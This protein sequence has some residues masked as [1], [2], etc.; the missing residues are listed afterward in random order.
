MKHA[1]LQERLNELVSSFGYDAVYKTLCEAKAAKVA[2]AKRDTKVRR[3]ANDSAGKPAA[4]RVKPTAVKIVNSIEITDSEK[5]EILLTMA[6]KYEEKEFMPSVN[7]V[8]NFLC[9]ER[10]VSRI[11]SR[12]QVT[13]A[14]FKKLARMETGKLREI[15]D[16]GTYAP[17]ATLRSIA[18]AIEGFN[19]PDHSNSNR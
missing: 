15:V 10:D 6:K 13:S 5:K 1:K 11:K 18:R 16:R 12:Q 3:T 7:Y 4:T 8:R 2:V 14:V 17:P 19:R 9:N